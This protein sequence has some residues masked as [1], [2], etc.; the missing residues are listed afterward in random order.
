MLIQLL[1]RC[2]DLV[3]APSKEGGLPLKEA[4]HIRAV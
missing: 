4:V 1:A 3:V 2:G